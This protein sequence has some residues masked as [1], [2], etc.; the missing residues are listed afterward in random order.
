MVAYLHASHRKGSSL[1]QHH[2]EILRSRCWQ[3]RATHYFWGYKLQIGSY[4]ERWE[5]INE[6]LW[7]SVEWQ[8]NNNVYYFHYHRCNYYFYANALQLLGLIIVTRENA[9]VLFNTDNQYLLRFQTLKPSTYIT[10]LLTVCFTSAAPVKSVSSAW[11]SSA[12]DRICIDI[13][14][15]TN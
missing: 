12:A 1:H 6:R 13:H 14:T 10:G 4:C 5:S 11:F 7:G 9:L 3:E 8:G 15:F 2:R